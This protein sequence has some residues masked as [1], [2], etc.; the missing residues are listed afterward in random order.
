MEKGNG[1][2]Q[3]GTGI[4]MSRWE[5]VQARTMVAALA[6]AELWQKELLLL[7]SEVARG[8][9]DVKDTEKMVF[10]PEGGL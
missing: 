1:V 8:I 7:L 2:G 10:V 9:V 5:M 4:P 3:I 6:E